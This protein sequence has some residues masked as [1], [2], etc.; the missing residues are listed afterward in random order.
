LDFE[1][2]SEKEIE[3]GSAAY[4]AHPSSEI[5]LTSYAIED[6]LVICTDQTDPNHKDLKPFFNAVVNEGHDLVAHN[7]LF[8]IFIWKYV[9]KRKYNWPT[10]KLSQMLCTMQMAARAGLPMKL[11]D[12]CKVMEVTEKLTE[13]KDLIKFFCKPQN[14]GHR[15]FMDDYPERKARF[16]EYG[17]VDVYGSRDLHINLPEWKEID[18]EDILLD[19]RSNMMGVPIDVPTS[20][21]ILLSCNKEQET[22]GRKAYNI[23]GGVITKMTQIK[24]VKDWVNSH[25]EVTIPGCGKD[26]V[27]DLLDNQRHLLDS[28]S[29]ELLEMRQHSGKSSTGKYD[30]YVN[31]NVDGLIYG[32]IISFGTHTHRTISKLLNLNNLPKPSVEYE[33]MYQLVEDFKNEDAQFINDQYGS[34]MKAAST[35][36]RGIITAPEGKKLFVADY[37]SIEARLVFWAA[38]CKDGLQKYHDGID[39]YIDMAATI[40]HIIYSEVN[41]SQRWVGKNAILGCGFGL[42]WK[43]FQ[44]TCRNYGRELSDELCQ[45]TIAAYRDAYYEV[46]EAW[47]DI[48]KAA[49][50]AVRTGKTT[51][52]L[53]GKCAFRTIKTKSG[54]VFL[55]MRKPNG[56]FLSYPEPRIQTV[57]TPWGARKKA[58]T[59]KRLVNN[60]WRR[61][62][63]YGGSLFENYI[64]AI[65]R[66]LMYFGAKEANKKGYKVMF[67]VYDEVI[68]LADEDRS[69]D[70]YIEALC[71]LPDWAVGL[72]L[73]ADGKK[74]VHYQKL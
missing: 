43:G 59:Y 32:M 28:S 56:T 40:Y 69:F 60:F 54:K 10:I 37:A 38:D 19:L 2:Y 57:T 6:G 66:D 74:L 3:Q 29:I 8:E 42:G 46:V 23:T 58:L 21:K 18:R 35:A 65:A 51:Y 13:G 72:P 67:S 68:A 17:K 11:E 31:G 14:D 22:F 48:E 15:N 63:T 55:L 1:T 64:Q 36:I 24:R 41:D 61:E 47:K 12:A 20:K 26:I 33:S 44:N 52:C 73:A 70:E 62:S 25:S 53:K 16:F 34:Y 30:R 9:A 5:L 27:E 4:A 71:M 39:N 45:L 50:L 7:M 49:M